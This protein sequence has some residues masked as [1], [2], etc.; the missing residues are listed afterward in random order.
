M[1]FPLAVGATGGRRV[2]AGSTRG[3]IWGRREAHSGKISTFAPGEVFS[4]RQDVTRHVRQG[5]SSGNIRNNETDYHT[6]NDIAGGR[7][8]RLAH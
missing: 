2:L 4:L 5:E 6:L 1:R 8:H 7:G 3:D